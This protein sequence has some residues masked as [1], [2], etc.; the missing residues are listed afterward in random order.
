MN[1]FRYSTGGYVIDNSVRYNDDDSPYLYRT[2]TVLGNRRTGSISLWYKRG[3]LGS[4]QQL[5]NSGA[6][7][8][9][10]FDA[11]D[12]LIWT[13]G[14]GLSY[15][16]TQVFRDPTAWGHLLFAW[17]TT[18]ATAGDR[19]R[20][21]HNGVEITAF[22]T[23]TNPD[24][25]DEFEISNTV[26][27]TIGANEGGTEE[28]DG[29]LS[30]VH[31][32]DGTQ[33][34]PTSFGEFDDNGVW[35]PIEFSTTGVTGYGGNVIPTMTS[36]S[37]PSGI[38]SASAE[39]SASYAA[40]KGVDGSTGTYWSSYSSTP[41]Q[42]WGYEFASAKT[43]TQ[44][45]I[46]A[47]GSASYDLDDWTFEGYNGS[48]W[49]VLDTV[50]GEAT[51]TASEKRVFQ[52]SNTTAYTKYQ[53]NVTSSGNYIGFQEIEMME[54][55]TGYGTNG[56]FLDFADSAFLGKDA[57]NGTGL[58]AASEGTV[59]GDL[60]LHGG[61]AAAF[62][63]NRTETTAGAANTGD[64]RY[65]GKTWGSLTT[66]TGFKIWAYTDKGFREGST[67][68]V[69][70]TLYGK[71]G[72]AP[73]NSSDGTSL[74]VITVSP[75]STTSSPPA[76]AESFGGFTAG[77][78]LHNW[79][80]ITVGSNC[81]VGEL[82]FYTGTNTREGNDFTP[83]G[84]ATTD[85]MSDTPT[86]NYCTWNPLLKTAA[87]MVYSDGNLTLQY[88]SSTDAGTAANMFVGS[89]KWYFEIEA[90]DAYDVIGIASDTC[91]ATGDFVADAYNSSLAGY[92]GD[93]AYGYFALNGNI[94]KPA[95]SG[96][97]GDAYADG[98]VIGVALDL[99]NNA[100]WFSKNDTWQN[101]ATIGEI[102][103]GT[104]TNAASTGGLT[105]IRWAPFK[106]QYNNSTVHLNC[107]QYAFDGT[108]PTGF[109]AINTANIATPTI[110]DGTAHHQATLYTGNTLNRNILQTGNSKFTP[111]FV[112]LK[113]R[114]T[115]DPN[116][117]YTSVLGVQKDLNIDDNTAANTN[118]NGLTAFSDKL[119]VDATGET[120]IGNST[121]A[122]GLANAFDGDNSKGYATCA[123]AGSSPGTIG[124]DW[125]S[126]NTKLITQ[127]ITVGSSDY[128]YSSPSR[129]IN[130]KLEGSTDNFSSS[131]VDL[132]GGTGDFA[133][134]T[135]NSFKMVT[136]T[137]TTAYRYHRLYITSS[138]GSTNVAQVQFFESNT[139]DTRG[140]T[141]GNGASG[142]N[143]NAEK[144]VAY[145]WL[146][147]GAASSNTSGTIT[148][149]VSVNAAGGISVGTYTG[150]GSAGTIGHGLSAVPHWI[151]TKNT[152]AAGL[153]VLYHQHNTSEPETNYLQPHLTTATADYP[154]WNDTAPTST[155]FSI[156]TDGSINTNT[157]LYSFWAFTEKESFSK[158]GI[159][160]GTGVN[161]GSYVWC[162]FKPSWLWIKGFDTAQEWHVYDNVKD[163][164]NSGTTGGRIYNRTEN[165]YADNTP[166]ST[167]NI[168]FLAN[169]FK[170]RD[171]GGTNLAQSYIFMA[172]AEHPFGGD[173]LTPATAV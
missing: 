91:A 135:A 128:G 104:T 77:A 111:D 170:L 9:I 105:G 69:T 24:Q 106:T 93:G 92:G 137:S 140:F 133:D 121:S 139:G 103:A 61:N 35:R 145:Q 78:Y 46:T 161:D 89:G 32:V 122:G 141:I 166:G 56:F 155:V 68:D 42:T 21:Y 12:Q 58:V 127:M 165:P 82:E 95:A 85:Q 6:G 4:I 30:Q 125:G 148:S 71:T 81:H 48:T 90:G 97:Y 73:A 3:N 55:S 65:I 136:P 113:N 167:E 47:R 160:E 23:E 27:Q 20:I 158:F 25:N 11:A 37:A 49:D 43:I 98:D 44:Y 88:I 41:T 8:D 168:D 1:P 38:A 172:F 60:T 84:L 132:G 2:P 64:D 144:F 94:Q 114:D 29:Y 115:T 99:E 163:T 134:A 153:W 157:Q 14:S 67:A 142:Y 16:T 107:G 156:G 100:I 54:A 66:I 13:D 26:D 10:A 126:G 110:L 147:G 109:N 112:W 33:L 173:G 143:D 151:M 149:S 19:A 31:L 75:D 5:F 17:N 70:I 159:Y 72:S 169:G 76:T 53:I 120:L 162:G 52:F 50:T 124:V 130:I 87:N 129:T 51:W 74:K 116:M 102:Q 150:T 45:V 59:I 86:T 108:Q 28:F 131:V 171:N 96:S 18:L 152:A 62:N 101:S 154:L 79:V 123:A 164:Y 34:T 80:K 146:G 36:N 119:L 40:W 138:V 63:S 57:A 7:D 117:L 22:A 39:E 83:T 118:F 15:K